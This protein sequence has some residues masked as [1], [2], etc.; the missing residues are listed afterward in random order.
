MTPG[1]E[2]VGEVLA[3]GDGVVDFLVGDRVGI[4]WLRETCGNCRFCRR[5]REN[6]CPGSRYTGWDAD[7][8]YAELAVV[9]AAY[10]LPLPTGYTD[11]EPAPLLCAGLI[12]YHALEQC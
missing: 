10:A 2:V 8:G 4:A 12:G 3:L 9:P 6:L 11:D 7:G 5:G 1:H